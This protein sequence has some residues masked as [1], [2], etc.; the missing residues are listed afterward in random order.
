[1]YPSEWIGFRVAL[2]HGKVE[3]YDS[4]V[5]DKGG[6]EYYRK[7][8]NLE[9]E[10]SLLEAYVATE[11]YPTVFLERYDGLQGKL[12][13]YGL[14]GIGMF[15]FNPKA[16]FYENNGTSRMV[17]LQPLRLEGQG[18]EEYPDRKQYS[19]TSMEIPMG[20]GA[21]YFIKENMYIGFEILHRKT[22]TDYVDNVSTNYIDAI[23]FDKYLSAEDARM[24]RQLH[25]R[26]NFVPNGTNVR[27]PPL[28]N[29]QRG[30]PSEKDSYFSTLLRFG[31]RLNDWNSPN[32]RA[33]RQ[34]RCPA[35]Y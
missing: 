35:Y 23:Y 1:V 13:P 15:R 30:D 2:N 31:W 32:G 8:R 25:F 4:Q 10:S 33:M 12:R 16:R 9:F 24:A 7:L 3:G 11:I 17:A 26:E 18:M 20:I 5:P 22:F 19:L 14:A 34:L 29:E 21:K 27:N 28:L 6:D